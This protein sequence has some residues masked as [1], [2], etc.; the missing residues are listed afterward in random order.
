MLNAKLH[1]VGLSWIISSS[2]QIKYYIKVNIHP[3]WVNKVPRYNTSKMLGLNSFITII[4]LDKMAHED[5]KK[6]FK[7]ILTMKSKPISHDKKYQLLLTD[8]VCAFYLTH[9]AA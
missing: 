8:I 1:Y 7:Q 2:N 6:H 3:D 9:L 4:K 5:M